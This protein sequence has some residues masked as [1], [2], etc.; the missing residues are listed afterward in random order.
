[1]T[2]DCLDVVPRDTTAPNEREPDFSV[3]DGR[4][5]TK[6]IVC[7]IQEMDGMV[8]GTSRRDKIRRR[9]AIG[10]N[11]NGSAIMRCRSSSAKKPTFASV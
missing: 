1:M 7:Q 5:A 2:L 8:P 6:Q 4:R 9:F 11:T 10:C 3:R